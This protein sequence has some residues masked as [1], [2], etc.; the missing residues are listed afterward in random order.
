MTIRA[1][2]AYKESGFEWIGRIPTSWNMVRTKDVFE[3]VNGATPKSDDP[4][5]WDGNIVWI[6][7]AD[8]S[9]I[10]GW[11][12]TYSSRM[13]TQAG[14]DACAASLVPPNS[15]ILSTRAPIGSIGIAAVDL[16][17]NQG[18]R[19]LVLRIG[20]TTKYFAYI[21]SVSSE[22]LNIRGR[23]TT[24]L[25]LPGESL[26]AFPLPLPPLAEQS[27][28]AAFLDRETGKIDALV[29]EQERLIALLKE[30]RQAVISHAVTKGLNPNAP[31]KDSGV[32]WLGEVPAHWQV[33]RLKQL[34]AVGTS[35]SYGIVQPGEP[36]ILGVPFVQTTN[37][38]SGQ[39]SFDS[40]QK[41]T[42]EIASGYPRS[43]L[44]GGEVLLG[45][46][47][48]IGAAFVAPPYLQGANLSRGVA[49]IVPNATIIA[50]YTVDF[51]GSQNVSHYWGQMRQGSTFNEVSIETVREMWVTVPPIPEQNDLVAHIQRRNSELDNLSAAAT[52]AITL[53]RERR[54]A[55]ISAAVTGKVDVRDTAP[56]TQDAA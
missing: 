40:L 49:R 3:I 27:A 11:S 37:M 7:P 34:V 9:N 17:I 5:Y 42:A 50:K 29:A 33:K 25:E 15:I 45:I 38:T 16:C 14:L 6:T 54:A 46:R 21:I 13:I 35:I 28:I 55:L 48:S 2:P 24:F 39:F 4:L 1:Y 23:G 30:K 47:A 22:Q 20:T 31:M 56:S 32:P 44:T 26:A 41:T 52:H 19:A 10:S 53:L 51:F 43:R 8:I 12:I 18:C 36:Q